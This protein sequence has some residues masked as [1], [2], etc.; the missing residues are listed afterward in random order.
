M[1]QKQKTSA[2]GSEAGQALSASK[3]AILAIGVFSAFI[4]I[5]MLSGPLYM[6]QVYDRV[7]ASGSMSTL[8]AISVLMALMYA[9]MGFLEYVRSRVL[10]RIGD[11]LEKD[12]GERTFSVWM[13]QGLVGRGGQRHR[14]LQDVSTLRQFL[15]GAAPAGPDL[16]CRYVFVSLEPGGYWDYWRSCYFHYRMAQRSHD[17]KTLARSQCS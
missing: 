3:Q 11:K 13:K 2:M 12:L 10:V 5:L 1:Q 4:N 15:S 6:L 17:A 7:L 14:P 16:Y 9:F 8:G